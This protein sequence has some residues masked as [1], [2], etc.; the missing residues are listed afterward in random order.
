MKKFMTIS[1]AVLAGA[2]VTGT[3]VMAD[4]HDSESSGTAMFTADLSPDQ[5]TADVESDA[6]GMAEFE[7]N[8]DQTEVTY[9]VEA[10]SL[11][12]VTMAHIHSGAEGEDGPVEVGLFDTDEAEDI[13]GELASGTFGEDDLAGDMDW[14]GLLEAMTN[15]GLYVNVHTEEY[16]DGEI[17]GQIMAHDMEEGMDNGMNNHDDADNNHDDADNNHDDNNAMNDHDDSDNGYADNGNDWDEEGNEMAQTS[18]NGPL[19]TMIGLLAATAGGAMMFFRRR[20]Q[21]Q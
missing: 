17:R 1:T 8:E 12:G 11:T 14:D 19:F 5:E 10:E 9:T 21:Q 7:L 20:P 6:S 16:P 13:D 2:A 18:T 15:E 4:S 3:S